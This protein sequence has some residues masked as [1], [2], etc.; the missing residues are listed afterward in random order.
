MTHVVGSKGQVVIPRQIRDKLDLRPGT[1]V[2]FE[3]LK[4]AVAVIPV[5]REGSLK[6]A[7]AG[8]GL[9]SA[10]AEDRALEPR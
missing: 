1:E 6:G 4:D 8:Q 5:G 7:F 9:L 3:L 10:L 2:D